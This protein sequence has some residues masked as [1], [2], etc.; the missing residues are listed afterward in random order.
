[1]SVALMAVALGCGGT[2]T[3]GGNAD[4][5]AGDGG[6][7]L[8]RD[9]DGLTDEEEGN[10]G[11]DPDNPDSDGDGLSD[12]DE[13][14]LGTDPLDPDSDGDGIPD[15]DEV[16]IGTDPLDPTDD[17]CAGD[18]AAADLIKQPADIIIMIDTSGSMGGEADAVEARINDDL[19]GNLESAGVD[20]KIIM[21]ADFP[22][23]DGGN[24]NDPTLCIGPPLAPQNC[25]NI[26]TPK[27]TNGADFFH[28][29]AHVDSR[30]SL[31]V[32]IDEFDDPAGDEGPT[33]GAGQITGGW[34]TLL[35]T[36]SR[37]FFMEISDDNANGTY[38]AD[39]FDTEIKAHYA[40]MYPAA[41]PLDYVFHSIIGI[42][43]N[44]AG[45]AWPATEPRRNGT[46]GQGAV[47]NGSVYQDLSIMTEGL[48]FPLCDNDDF[49]A[50]FSA[51]ADDVVAGVTL[52]CSYTPNSTGN[53]SID[54]DKSA[55]VF[56]PSDGSGLES[57]TRVPNAGA[58]V[59]GGYYLDT[60]DFV[61]CPATCDRVRADDAGKVTLRVGCG[62]VVVD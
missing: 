60:V 42:E 23:D 14:D 1:M 40:A 46:C 29:D 17:S 12:G 35:R 28:Y 19:A 56:E 47:N 38:D 53:G 7:G 4:G 2:G 50:I 6:A 25:S 57:L 48:R 26:T 10:L 61:L 18:Q 15:G 52:P 49:D 34:G 20:Y 31:V 59:D 36:D 44:P 21:I 33:S 58:C 43:A 27:P 54:L 37:K 32:A 5:G 55:V 8:D 51:I 41:D 24:A 13:V 62:D 39:E 30:D 11:T 3:G 45:G 16:A 9:G 22:P